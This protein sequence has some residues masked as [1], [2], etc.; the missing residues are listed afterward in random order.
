MMDSVGKAN[1]SMKDNRQTGK[2]PI[3]IM[4][5]D[6]C[7]GRVLSKESKELINK[8]SG[9]LFNAY[10]ARERKKSDRNC[11]KDL[12]PNLGKLTKA[13]VDII[14]AEKPE[15]KGKLEYDSKFSIVNER[16]GF[17]H[18]ADIA[19]VTMDIRVPSKKLC[20]LMLRGGNDL[21]VWHHTRRGGASGAAIYMGGADRLADGLLKA[22]KEVI[23]IK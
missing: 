2:F 12:E 23:N 9:K 21:Y 5:G 10:N 14:A 16:I 1:F 20:G 6:I 11:V 22:V 13:I 4:A 18:W 19:Q 7:T 8:E 15:L 3:I 17:G